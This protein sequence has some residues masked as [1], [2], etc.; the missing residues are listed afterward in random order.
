MDIIGHR[1]DSPRRLYAF[2]ELILLPGLARM[3]PREITTEVQLGDL[4]LN[5]P[6]LSSPMDTVTEA[7]MA[8]AVASNGGLGVI[9]RNCTVEEAAAMVREVKKAPADSG[10]KMAVRDRKGRLAVGAGIS[11]LDTERAVALAEEA[12]LLVSDVASSYNVKV[13]EGAKKVIK[14]TG[15]KIVIGNLG[16]RQGVLHT[17]KELGAENVAAVRVGMGSGSICTTTDV[18]GVGSPVPFATEQAALA[19]SELHLLDKIPIIAD[20]GLRHT[21]DIAFSFCLGASLAMLG[22]LFARCD[23]SPGERM[24]K[25]G[26]RYKVYWGM[27]SAEARKK[28]LAVDRY[29][30]TKG[31]DVNEGIKMTVPIEGTAAEVIERLLAELKITIGYIGARNI[32]EMREVAEFAVRTAKEPKEGS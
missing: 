16:T 22:N 25:D 21:R 12:D 28:R 11:P 4:T 7:K 10:N 2:E 1:L 20:G 9:H 14:A 26:K 8:I 19:L 5:A 32:K 3:S 27:G 6:F 15:K 13:I 23:E 31:K 17:I 18:S 29:Q 24:T 30:E